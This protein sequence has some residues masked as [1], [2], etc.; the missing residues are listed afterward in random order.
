MNDLP[1]VDFN[2][3]RLLPVTTTHINSRRT[4]DTTAQIG[5]IT[6]SVPFLVPPMHALYSDEIARTVAEFGTVAVAPR[7]SF[8]SEL[9]GNPLIVNTSIDDALLTAENLLR[10]PQTSKVLSIEVANGHM[11]K[12]ADKIKEVKDLYPE[13]AVWAG[14][15]ITPDAV[16][17]LGRSGATAVLIG[18]GVGSA[19][20]TTKKTGIGLP[21][22]FTTLICAQAEYPVILTGGL[23]EH[24]DVAKAL[25]AG[26]TAVYCG[27][28]IKGARDLPRPDHYFGEASREAGK[29][30][31][32]E[33]VDLIV[34]PRNQSVVEI[35]TEMKEDLQS[36]MSYC[37]ATNLSQFYNN[38]RYSIID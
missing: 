22:F 10:Y 16:E 37:D 26:A 4:I 15:V 11:Q 9:V 8:G 36:A 21:A 20:I 28:L 7:K 5:D 13:L 33:G 27:A 23:R 14:T 34:K 25:A 12:L 31:H 2:R 30:S 6:L 3:V 1:N 18:I 35:L 24:G 19:C 29:R 38:V 17:V 32:I